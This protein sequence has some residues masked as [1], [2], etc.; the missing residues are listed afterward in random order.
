MNILDVNIDVRIIVGDKV[1]F[2]HNGNEQMYT[3]M[4]KAEIKSIKY[5]KGIQELEI[6]LG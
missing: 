2:Y 4:G 1:K 5:L 3:D 6:T